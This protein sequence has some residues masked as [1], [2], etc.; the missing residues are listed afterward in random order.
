M[1]REFHP[2]FLEDAAA[3]LFWTLASRNGFGP[4]LEKVLQTEGQSVLDCTDSETIF[5]RY[6]LE[7]MSATTFTALCDAVAA[8]AYDCAVSEENLVGM[9][10]SEDRFTG[11][12]P[13]AADISTSHLDLPLTVIGDT[14]PEY[15]MLCLRH[16]LPAVVFGE[17]MPPEG[18]FRVADTTALG[19]GMPLWLHPHTASQIESG[20]WLLTG[21]FHIPENLDLSR[22]PWTEV[23]PNAVCASSGM[24]F[25]TWGNVVNL[26]FVW[27]RTP[28]EKL[29][30]EETFTDKLRASALGRLFRGQS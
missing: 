25:E 13:S 28:Q 9:V 24:M 23:I 20:V 4:T 27:D 14:L 30:T 6:P 1:K 29:P 5:S 18:L 22:R 8:Y 3:W 12:S 17:G 21:I 2:Q 7:G 16:P 19:F 11:R 10:Y 15:G 26:E